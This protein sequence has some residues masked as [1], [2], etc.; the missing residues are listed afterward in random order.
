M[1]C[2]IKS[3]SLILL[4]IIKL[5]IKLQK[6]YAV[7]IYICKL[8]S[9]FCIQYRHKLFIMVYTSKCSCLLNSILYSVHVFC[10]LWS[11]SQSSRAKSLQLLPLIL[12]FSDWRLMCRR[13]SFRQMEAFF[14]D[15]SKKPSKKSDFVAIST[16]PL[17]SKIEGALVKWN[18]LNSVFPPWWIWLES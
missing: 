9:H 6:N 1:F 7:N 2:E 14:N 11:L 17:R 12:P 16:F 13:L 5:N 3:P 8:A 4:E 15:S 10:I 18:Q